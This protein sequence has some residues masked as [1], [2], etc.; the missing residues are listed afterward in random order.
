[1]NFFYS[2]P[3]IA[4]GPVAISNE[5][6]NH[7]TNIFQ[8]KHTKKSSDNPTNTDKSVA[9]TS[10]INKNII[11]PSVIVPV[12]LKQREKRKLADAF[13]SEYNKKLKPNNYKDENHR[14]DKYSPDIM[15]FAMTLQGKPQ[16]KKMHFLSGK[17]TFFVK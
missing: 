15:K 9:N 8:T 13:I 6:V 3:F 7:P 11:R 16:I 4:E 1:M 2:F 14:H 17:A 5:T 10:D 12:N